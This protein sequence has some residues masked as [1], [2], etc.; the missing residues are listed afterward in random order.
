MIYLPLTPPRKGNSRANVYILPLQGGARGGAKIATLLLC[1]LSILPHL[2]A[3]N[4][5]SQTFYVLDQASNQLRPDR[6]WRWGYDTQ[7]RNTKQAG[8]LWNVALNS[9]ERSFEKDFEY[10]SSGERSA[11]KSR[12]WEEDGIRLLQRFWSYND[13]GQALG[14]EEY[15][16][17]AGTDARYLQT[18]WE[19]SYTTEG[20]LSEKVYFDGND[21]LD[22]RERYYYQDDCR[23][24]S[25]LLETYDGAWQAQARTIYQYLDSLE[26]TTRE[27]WRDGAF[28][29][30]NQTATIFDDQGQKLMET[31]LFRDSSQSRIEFAYDE[32]GNT[33]WFRSSQRLAGDSLWF[34]VQEQISQYN[35]ADQPTQQV[36]RFGFDPLSRKF[37]QRNYRSITYDEDGRTTQEQ[38]K[39]CRK[40]QTS[41]MLGA[42]AKPELRKLSWSRTG[43]GAI[44]RAN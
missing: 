13:K 17:D 2:S 16:Q 22:R 25:L 35:V 8:W 32:R 28:V 4:I 11:E 10:H 1:I 21:R 43:L 23:L 41:T 34:F 29:F 3:Q 12:F 44:N 40:S 33:L 18:R 38:I 36:L 42:S 31:T 9:Y 5:S 14:F 27:N 19:A 39:R 6:E 20:C 30:Q 24:D 37:S 7:G 15:R 26:I